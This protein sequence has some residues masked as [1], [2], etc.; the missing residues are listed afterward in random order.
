MGKR[1]INISLDTDISDLHEQK[2]EEVYDIL[3]L[4]KES[5]VAAL[6]GADDFAKLE[7]L[8]LDAFEFTKKGFFPARGASSP[9]I[10]AK[11]GVCAALKAGGWRV[12]RI[13][14]YT[15]VTPR[16]VDKHLALPVC[17]TTTQPAYI[18]IYEKAK[19]IT[20]NHLGL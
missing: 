8:L 14:R 15:G 13:S 6:Y 17:A 11:A 10:Y 20:K 9:L 18:N 19:T 4:A 7:V 2:Q 12:N 3:Q 16:T 1:I 5:I